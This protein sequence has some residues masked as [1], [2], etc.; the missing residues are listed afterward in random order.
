VLILADGEGGAEDADELEFEAGHVDAGYYDNP[1]FWNYFDLGI[2]LLF[3]TPALT[4][5]SIASG[6]NAS[7]AN[8]VTRLSSSTSSTGAAGGVLLKV[9]VHS[10]VPGSALFQRYNR[11]PWVVIPPAAGAG[12]EVSFHEPID[13]LSSL[14]GAADDR[15]ELDRATDA[16]F[17][18]ASA[19]TSA[20]GRSGGRGAS[21][22][23]TSLGDAR[24]KAEAA[25]SS[26]KLD[27][28]TW[29]H[30]FENRADAAKADQEV[31]EGGLIAEADGAGRICSVLIY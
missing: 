1:T 25:S 8:S 21:N 16:D 31:P 7:G 18:P 17:L 20:S 12:Q 4:P 19:R 30:G 5:A 6:S 3:S 11:C 28:R 27:V 10:N 9:I 23:S 24:S 14:L 29:L 26:L 2:D 22:A 15:I 13:A